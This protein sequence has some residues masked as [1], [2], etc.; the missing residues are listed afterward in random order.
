VYNIFEK[1]DEIE[2]GTILDPRFR[3]IRDT[4]KYNLSKIKNYYHD[5]DIL[6]NNNHFLVRLLNDS[7]IPLSYDIDKYMDIAY[8]RSPF[9]AKLYNLTSDRSYGILHD[10]IF[11]NGCKEIILYV[12]DYVDI[13]DLDNWTELEPVKVHKHPISDLS[14]TLP[15]SKNYYFFNELSTIS[16][17]IP[18]L[19]GMYRM[20][21]LDSLYKYQTTGSG[22]KFISKYVIP[23]MLTSQTNIACVNRLESLFTGKPFTKPNYKHALSMSNYEDKI[24]YVYKDFLKHFKNKNISYSR[25][26]KN[27]PTI[28]T[29]AEET[30]LLPDITPTRQAWWSLVITRLEEI[31]FLIDLGGSKGKRR[32]RGLTWDRCSTASRSR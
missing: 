30:L 25:V 12:E 1:I 11:Y 19:L 10:G 8:T 29:N 4:Y 21:Q 7:S 23:N 17:N 9:I 3:L 6:V 22:A 32:N 14:L 2:S 26:L 5:R 20:Y 28:T 24:D 16:I 13:N 15:S 18:L 27:I 31:K